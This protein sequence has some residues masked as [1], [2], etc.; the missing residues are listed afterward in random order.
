MT[1]SINTHSDISPYKAS[2]VYPTYEKITSFYHKHLT[3]MLS[4]HSKVFQARFDLHLPLKQ[5][6]EA[7][8]QIRDFAENFTRD[9]N[10]N[11]PLPKE[12]RQRSC[13]R[14]KQ[15][16]QVDPRVIWV[17]EQHDESPHHHYHCLVLTNGNAKQSSHDIHKRAERQWANALDLNNSSG[18]VDYCNRK[19][20]SSIMINRNS[21]EFTSQVH[22]AQEQ[23]SY[24]AKT[25]GKE[26]KPKYKWKVGGTRLPDTNK[27][28]DK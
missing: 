27:L 11:N 5:V 1:N 21:S 6:Q 13:G 25:R 2:K 17:R 18:L 24:L 10:R 28:K 7:P 3:D 9:L 15:K 14:S 23:A 4:K 12:G 16:H 19:K 22:A 8:K 20:P 26:E